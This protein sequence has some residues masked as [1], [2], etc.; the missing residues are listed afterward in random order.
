MRWRNLHGFHNIHTSGEEQLRRCRR[1]W[2]RYRYIDPDGTFFFLPLS[3]MESLKSSTA[4]L[5]LVVILILRAQRPAR[6]SFNLPWAGAA[7]FLRDFRGRVTWDDEKGGK[8]E[9]CYSVV[10]HYTW[11]GG[12]LLFA[13]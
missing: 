9:A 4:L 12:G 7:P 8:R 10:H 3:F 5:F 2:I 11:V 1:L 6:S 13:T